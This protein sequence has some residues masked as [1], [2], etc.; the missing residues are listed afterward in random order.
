MTGGGGGLV[1][2][3]EVFGELRFSGCTTWGSSRSASGDALRA[4]CLAAVYF[5]LGYD[6]YRIPVLLVRIL[7]WLRG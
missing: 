1:S 3:A 7:P 5:H 6:G 4:L 2:G